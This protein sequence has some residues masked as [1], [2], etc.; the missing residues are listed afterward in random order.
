M[1]AFVPRGWSSYH[2][3]Q[4]GLTRRFTHGLTFQ[5]AYTWSH[6][7]DNS[8]A[9]FHTSDITPRR[10]QDFFNFASE[11]SNSALDRAQRFT[12]AMIYELPFFKGGNWLMKN[13]VGNWSFS[14][15]YTYETGEWVTVQAQRDANLNVDSAGDRVILNPAGIRGTGTDVTA[16]CRVSNPC[17]PNNGVI[18][19][20]VAKNPTAQ[21]IRPG[22]G[23]L[24]NTGRNTLQTP[25]TNNIDLG[26]YKDVN[27]TEKMKFR[28]GAQFGNIINHPQFIPGSNPGFGLGV[29][30]V[31]GFSSV[32]TGYKAFVTPGNA[33]F[34]N[35][36]AVFAS[37]ART[38]ALL[39]KFSF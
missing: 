25:G 22:L 4:A 23:A 21:Y 29:N 6:T 19:A 38:I 32:G 24:A 9:D 12:L 11:K 14:P 35:P 31:N 10:P 1:T 17:D 33:N 26:I 37:N 28:F 8:T 34:N 27:F 15:V 5:S 39:A 30:D 2:G 7:I 20:Y 16:L 13:V 36:R 18:V 3:L